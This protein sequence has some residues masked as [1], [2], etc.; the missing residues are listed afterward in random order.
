MAYFSNG[1]EGMVFD[2]QCCRCKYGKM[3]CPIAWV[4]SYYNYS[5]V[6]NKVA[7]AIL[8]YL[9]KNDG[10]CSMYEMGKKDFFIDENQVEMKF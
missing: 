7:T 8:N 2:E 4:Q 5:A 1:F 9:V 3:P 6:G 10:T